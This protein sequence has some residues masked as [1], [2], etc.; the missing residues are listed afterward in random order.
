M[1]IIEGRV[2]VAASD[3]ANF[4][5]C[6]QLTQLHT[7]GRRGGGWWRC[8]GRGRR[9]G[10]IP[11]RW[12]SHL[13]WSELCA[14]RQRYDDDLSLVAGMTTGAQDEDTMR[15]QCECPINRNKAEV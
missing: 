6:Q 5:A 4:L 12:S 13:R 1:K 9:P 14:G 10:C 15:G 3:V 8:S 7:S 11:S 2:R